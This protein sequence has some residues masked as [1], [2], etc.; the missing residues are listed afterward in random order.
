MRFEQIRLIRE[1]FVITMTLSLLG[2]VELVSG[3]TVDVTGTW[4]LEVTTDQG[5]TRPSFRLTQEG[6]RLSGSYSSEAL[7]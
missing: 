1:L 3:Q 2:S 7:G 4:N 5:V 6:E